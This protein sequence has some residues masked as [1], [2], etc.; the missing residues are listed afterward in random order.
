[1]AMDEKT[2]VASPS[3]S[4]C[5]APREGG[6]RVG[7]GGYVQWATFAGLRE[8]LGQYALVYSRNE[9]TEALR[10]S[11]RADH[12]HRPPLRLTHSTTHSL[13]PSL[14]PSLTH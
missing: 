8:A 3:S 1:M 4:A 7:R 12:R 9:I 2:K 13:Y 6:R 5:S 11:L 14:T 10:F